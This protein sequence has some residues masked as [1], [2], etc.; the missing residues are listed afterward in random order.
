MLLIGWLV[1]VIT[2]PGVVVHELAHKSFCEFF[3]VNVYEVVYFRLVGNPIGYVLHEPARNLWQ[4]FWITVGPFVV[5][6]ISAFSLGLIVGLV[7]QSGTDSFLFYFLTWLAVSIGMHSFP[8]MADAKSLWA[9]ASTGNAASLLGRILVLPA[10]VLMGLGSIL[11]I[12]WLDAAYSISIVSVGAAVVHNDFQFAI[13]STNQRYTQNPPPTIYVTPVV[14]AP[15]VDPTSEPIAIS[16]ATP[17]I[18]ANMTPIAKRKMYVC[19]SV[20]NVRSGP[21]TN[22]PVTKKLTDEYEITVF[23]NIGE[24]Y[25]VGYDNDG[26]DQF[27]HQ[28]VLCNHPTKIAPSAYNTPTPQ[29]NNTLPYIS[30]AEIFARQAAQQTAT[31]LAHTPTP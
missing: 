21:G 6:S 2:F 29:D 3:G 27:M 18:L 15:H 17:H 26:I 12:F 31:A 19:A 5:N 28:I 7:S 11:S 25:Y 9:S 16:Q 30:N 23:G 13:T 14:S 1:G 20:A 22:Y 24:W 4:S 10:V 8:S